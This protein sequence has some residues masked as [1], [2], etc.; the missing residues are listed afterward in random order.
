[1]LPN[2]CMFCYTCAFFALILAN[3]EYFSRIRIECV[4]RIGRSSQPSTSTSTSLATKPPRS[5][6]YPPEAT[7][8]RLRLRHLDNKE[9]G[10]TETTLSSS[11]TTA[12]A[13]DL[14]GVALNISS[15]S[16][17][18]SQQSSGSSKVA[19]QQRSGSQ[20]Q[21]SG[22]SRFASHLAN[23]PPTSSVDLEAITESKLNNKKRQV[24]EIERKPKTEGDMEELKKASQ[25]VL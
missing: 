15:S 19:S 16:R 11:T 18:G 14:S 13:A 24:G 12:V 20:Q 23:Q 9:G 2:Y 21:R 10:D 25:A 8:L 22:S 1:M 17:F 7:T 3:N 5:S 4:A 6:R